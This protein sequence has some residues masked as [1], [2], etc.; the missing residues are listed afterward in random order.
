[1]PFLKLQMWTF[2]NAG[3][4]HMSNG[5]LRDPTLPLFTQRVLPFGVALDF[6]KL[7]G[8]P[9]LEYNL[10]TFRLVKNT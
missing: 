6:K 4:N 9:I 10:S 7:P 3:L 2:A 8:W 1:M 5:H